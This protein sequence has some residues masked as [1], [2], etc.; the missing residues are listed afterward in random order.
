[1]PQARASAAAASAV[2]PTLPDMAPLAPGPHYA[3][4]SAPVRK[5]EDAELTLAQVHKVLGPAMSH[6]R[7]Q[8]MPSPQGYVVT[9]WPL[10]TQPDAERLADV[11]SRRGVPMKWL[12]F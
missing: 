6:L 9:L 5:R 8:I 11:L 12:E 10:P 7:A 3:L 1:M 2:L 4:V